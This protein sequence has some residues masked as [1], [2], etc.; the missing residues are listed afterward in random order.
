M[1]VYLQKHL[2][3]SEH[4]NNFASESKLQ[5]YEENIYC[6]YMSLLYAHFMRKRRC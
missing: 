1:D 3:A 6:F 4:F 5:N 2:L